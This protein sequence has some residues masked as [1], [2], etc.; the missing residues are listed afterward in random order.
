MSISNDVNARAL[1][2]RELAASF[3]S[4]FIWG[5]ATASYQ[6]EGAVHE[7]GRT[8][9][10]WDTFSATPGKVF[11]GDTGDVADDHYHRWQ[12]DISLMS[13]LGLGAYRFSIAWP[14]IIPTGRGPINARGLDFYERLVDSLLVKN[15]Q[16]YATLYHWDLP[17]TLQDQGG[18]NNRDT[19]YAF[20]EYAE[21]VAQRLGDRIAG[22]IT[23]NEPWCASFL[24][25]G[26]GV[27]AP[28]LQDKQIAVNAAHHLMLSHGL[29]VPRLRAHTKSP[30]GITLN[31]G[32]IYPADDRP[33]T[34][35]DIGLADLLTNRWFLDPIFRGHYP[36]G[37]FEAMAVNPPPIE[38]DDLQTISTPIDF[39]G[40]NNYT[41]AVVRGKPGV[42]TAYD[43]E[44]VAS[45][46]GAHYTAMDWEVYPQGLE[47]LLVRLHKEYAIPQLYVTENGAAFQDEWS[48]GDI[49]HDPLRVDFLHDYIRGVSRA[50][51]QGV[52]LRGY[53]VW[54][55][56]D[57]FEWAEGYSKRFGIVYVD[58]PTQTRILKESAHWYA[59]L[60]AATR[61]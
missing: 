61:Q 35:H 22:W 13:G 8:P 51:Q 17:Q 55:L 20:A 44:T 2:T 3:P 11:Q 48:G 30:V 10:I 12:Q 56:L 32:S 42:S 5:V 18:W 9:S 54:S 28:G 1:A 39:L 45:I 50:V 37:F 43:V 34:K 16:P 58:Y 36:D 53:F 59:E 24:G 47:D 27:H 14:R 40:V 26:V 60:V 49:V 29:A 46:P 23:H 41:R 33:E 15:I 52:P 57:N 25:Y 6:I 19:A 38:Q 21:A 4:D 7:D 31:L